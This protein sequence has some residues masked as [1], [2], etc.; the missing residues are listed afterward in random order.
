MI[1]FIKQTSSK[2]KKQQ[3]QAH[4]LHIP[5]RFN[6]LSATFFPSMNLFHLPAETFYGA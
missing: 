1:Q 2:T 5:Q 4:D 6:H 3:N